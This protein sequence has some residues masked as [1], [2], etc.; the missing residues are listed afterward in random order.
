MLNSINLNAGDKLKNNDLIPEIRN[1]VPIEPIVK[2]FP[3]QNKFVERR[4]F[5][6]VLAFAITL[7]KAQGSTLQWVPTKPG[8]PIW[9]P[10]MDPNMDPL[11][12]PI[13]DP[14]AMA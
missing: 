4:Q 9:T 12:D 5:P 10:N 11:M 13:M 6:L 14:L 8:P 3:H 1:Y 7:H 2:K